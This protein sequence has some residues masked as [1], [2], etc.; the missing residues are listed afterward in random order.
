MIALEQ[1]K[2]HWRAVD[3]ETG[4]VVVAREEDLVSA[5]KEDHVYKMTRV[6]P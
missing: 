3:Q 2:T 5:L 4:E 6:K 1:Q